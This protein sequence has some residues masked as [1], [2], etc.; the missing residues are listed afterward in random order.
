[1]KKLPKKF[2]KDIETAFLS[3]VIAIFPIALMVYGL[4]NFEMDGSYKLLGFIVYELLGVCIIANLVWTTAINIEQVTLDENGITLKRLNKVICYLDWNAIEEVGIKEIPFSLQRK[5]VFLFEVYFSAAVLREADR[6][7]SGVSS[8]YKKRTKNYVSFIT[9][10]SL[11]C[12]EAVLPAHRE[13][14]NIISDK[15][16]IKEMMAD[17]P[18]DTKSCIYS[19]STDGLQYIAWED[20]QKLRNRRRIWLTRLY[21]GVLIVMY[22]LPI[23]LLCTG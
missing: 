13:W 15:A 6:V 1:M 7:R 16:M 17:R 12:L 18:W 8:L 4:I 23:F 11:T 9:S 20:Y 19:T 2:T 10:A 21:W 14:L 22:V 3:A 5:Y